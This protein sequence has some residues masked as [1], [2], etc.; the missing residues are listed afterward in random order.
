[1]AKD[2]GKVMEWFTKF[3]EQGDMDGQYSLGRCYETGN[4]VDKTVTKAVELFTK[5]SKPITV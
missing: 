5:A 1:M 4:G 2:L 3:A